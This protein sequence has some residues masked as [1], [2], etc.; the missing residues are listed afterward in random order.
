MGKFHSVKGAKLNDRQKMVVESLGGHQLVIASAGSGN[1]PRAFRDG[2]AHHAGG[3][4]R[5]RRT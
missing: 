4:K 1:R 2:T 5:Q 3:F